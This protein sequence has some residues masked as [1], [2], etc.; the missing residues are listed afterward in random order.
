M[1]P[2]QGLP[3]GR[4]HSYVVTRFLRA[5]ARGP[6]IEALVAGPISHHD[7]AAVRAARSVLLV[8]ERALLDRS[9]SL[10]SS[11]AATACSWDTV[12]KSSKNSP[13]ECPP[14]REAGSRGDS[15]RPCRRSSG[16]TQ[17][18]ATLRAPHWHDGKVADRV[19]DQ[20][21]HGRI[22]EVRELR[23]RS[24]LAARSRRRFRTHGNKV[25]ALLAAGVAQFAENVIAHEREASFRHEA[26]IVGKG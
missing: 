4:P 8:E 13:R 21:H 23:L 25:K 18:R 17:K 2:S 10:A 6:A 20:A 12:G 1:P 14:S 22:T 9:N 26:R 24:A 3:R 7:R 16:E 19:R 15:G 11:S 5:S